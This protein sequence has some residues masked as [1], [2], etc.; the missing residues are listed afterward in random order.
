MMV[1]LSAT[2][3]VTLLCTFP[4]GFQRC[5]GFLQACLKPCFKSFRLGI[6]Y[7]TA[8]VQ[9][10]VSNTSETASI[11]LTLLLS[12]ERY[13]AMHK[14]S[15]P[16]LWRPKCNVHNLLCY[17]NK[18]QHYNL[19]CHF[20]PCCSGCHQYFKSA[21]RSLQRLFSLFNG[22]VLETIVKFIRIA[23][24][25]WRGGR[26]TRKLKRPFS[27]LLAEARFNVHAKKDEPITSAATLASNRRNERRQAAQRKLT[28]LLVAIVG[29]FLAGQIPQAFAYV[30]NVQVVLRLF[31]RSSQSLACCP[32]YRLYRAITNCICLITYSA[33][34]FLYA[35]LN[36]HFKHQLGKWIG[37]CNWRRRQTFRT[38]TLTA[39]DSDKYDIMEKVKHRLQMKE[40]V[41]ADGYQMNR[42]TVPRK[43]ALS[44]VSHEVPVTDP[45][46]VPD[47]CNRASFYSYSDYVW[48]VSVA[49]LPQSGGRPVALANATLGRSV[50]TTQSR[51]TSPH[52]SEKGLHHASSLPTNHKSISNDIV[53]PNPSS[54]SQTSCSLHPI[55]LRRISQ[56]IVN[57]QPLLK[58]AKEDF[59]TAPTDTILVRVHSH[60]KRFWSK[61]RR[62]LAETR[63]RVKFKKTGRPVPQQSSSENQFQLNVT[64]QRFH[65]MD[66]QC[67]DRSNLQLLLPPYLANV[68]WCPPFIVASLLRANRRPEDATNP[69]VR[70]TIPIVYQ[71]THL[72][73]IL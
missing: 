32:S 6:S 8:Y 56:S 7:Y 49:I 66:H 46:A 51:S 12:I 59:S 65:G 34:F 41:S 9:F 28:V 25:R 64:S 55:P 13:V 19:K 21:I 33:N 14:I 58:Q 20:P 11:F 29:L 60:S 15:C 36:S 30:S 52:G 69:S 57:S 37:M 31:G 42:R 27:D 73:N 40:T 24:A 3:A 38:Q 18:S 68:S 22:N 61:R 50:T 53:V 35:S 5:K 47:D 1:A 45:I 26:K 48:R 4:L 43:M 54:E 2:D 16:G 70:N 63:K 39:L 67:R 23:N 72:D 17:Q 44:S 71:E 10:P 62:L